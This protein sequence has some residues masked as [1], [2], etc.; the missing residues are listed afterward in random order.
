M[1]ELTGLVDHGGSAGIFLRNMCRDG[2]ID[3]PNSH[4]LF[5]EW[6][7]EFNYPLENNRQLLMPMVYRIPAQTYFYQKDMKIG[8]IPVDDSYIIPLTLDYFN[9]NWIGDGPHLG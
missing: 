4:W 2:S 6:R 7:G 5:D 1:Q 8:W 9:G 3:V